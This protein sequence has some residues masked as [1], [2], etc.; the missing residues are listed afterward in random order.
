MPDAAPTLAAIAPFA[1]GPTR[2]RGIGHL[3]HK[4]SDRIAALAD[5]LYQ[6]GARVATED[7][8]L[9]IEP[10]EGTAALRA[11]TMDPCG[12]HRIAMALALTGLRVPGVRI[13]NPEVVA[14]SFPGFWDALSQLGAQVARRENG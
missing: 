5:G 8:A 10:P 4:E 12:D 14:K 13:R 11:G 2:I 6:L 9:A 7:D 1:E 3:R